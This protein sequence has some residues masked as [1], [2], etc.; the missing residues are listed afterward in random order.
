MKINQINPSNELKKL[1]K[2]IGDILELL[3]NNVLKN[4]NSNIKIS[5]QLKSLIGEKDSI[6]STL[7]KLGNLLI[8]IDSISMG[9]NES[10]T[11]EINQLDIE[12][13]REF[14]NKKC[15]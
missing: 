6:V 9:G 14:F 3:E 11:D 7:Y 5:N 12:I 4:K 15:N 10:E 13:I 8:K 2:I 1:R